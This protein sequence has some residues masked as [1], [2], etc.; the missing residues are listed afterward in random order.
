MSDSSARDL[1]R[2]S[3][4][5]AASAAPRAAA[6]GLATG[7]PLPTWAVV[8]IFCVG[9]ALAGVAGFA[10]PRWLKVEATLTRSVYYIEWLH[11]FLI[12]NVMVLLARAH[13]ADWAATL[14]RAA[15]ALGAGVALATV[16]FLAT[17]P[18]FRV[19]ADETNLLGSSLSLWLNGTYRNITEG[20]YYYD[21]FHVQS[22]VL[23]GRPAVYPFL[24]AV[25][26]SVLGFNPAHAYYV[27]FAAAAGSI[28]LA[29][30]IGTRLGGRLVGV[31]SALLLVASPTFALTSASA[32]YDVLNHLLLLLT[33][34]QMLWFLDRPSTLRLELLALIAVAAAGCRY[35]SILLIVPVAVAALTRWRR[36]AWTP[37]SIA[38]L[39]IV[40]FLYVP[41]VWQRQLVSATNGGEVLTD[42]PV[43][44]LQHLGRNLPNLAEFLLDWR[45]KNYPMVPAITC[46]A[47]LGL[48]LLLWRMRG[49]WRSPHGFVLAAA[50]VMVPVL[51]AIHLGYYLGD[52][53]Q[54]FLHRLG[55]LYATPFALL[56][57]YFLVT[58]TRRVKWEAAAVVVA[59]A[60][61]VHGLGRSGV[62]EQGRWLL[63]FREYKGIMGFL[64]TK[65]REGTMMV[66][67]RPGM[68]ASHMYG[69]MNIASLNRRVDDVLGG[70]KR[71]LYWNVYVEQKVYY[72]KPWAPEPAIDAR[73]QT[74]TVHE[75]QNDSRYLVRISRI[76]LDDP[77]VGPPAPP[78]LPVAFGPWKPSH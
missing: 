43:F 1:R 36:L 32:G 26:H 8:A 49:R 31:I 61:C 25:L 68:Y 67:D 52:I 75:F 64:E 2:P 9:G 27:N 15:P 5:Q 60:F 13:E 6:W 12:A 4:E 58:L 45:I 33:F 24:M 35:E 46:G 34:W 17:G 3:S 53:R 66:S 18:E 16:T 42:K 74:E 48:G 72:D 76:V 19:L 40:P 71:R 37:G 10:V 20:Y 21:T 22:S 11:V 63:L 29:A 28:A 23:D 51:A 73:Y 70:I 57:A 50:M 14:R 41:L 39:L 69:A 7:A 62:N 78:S 30:W 65:P 47:A 54:A 59:L 56:T 55:I 44:G 77:F 38:R